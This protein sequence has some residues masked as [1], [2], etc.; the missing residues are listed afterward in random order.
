MKKMSGRKYCHEIDSRGETFSIKCQAASVLY[1]QLSLTLVGLHIVST[2]S[3][4]TKLHF[5]NYFKKNTKCSMT[6]EKRKTVQEN[7]LPVVPIL[8][9]NGALNL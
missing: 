7:K 2:K 5:N 4:P 1:I 8:D 6:C 3:K 9:L